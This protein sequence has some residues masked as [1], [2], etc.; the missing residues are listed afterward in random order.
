MF[1]LCQEGKSTTVIEEINS[2]L[3]TANSSYNKPQV[4]TDSDEE[5]MVSDLIYAIH[6]IAFW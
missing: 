2:R 4:V 3:M 6:Y 1:K 5:N